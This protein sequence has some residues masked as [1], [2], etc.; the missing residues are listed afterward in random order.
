MDS[1]KLGKG[2]YKFTEEEIKKRQIS[3]I[4]SN[5]IKEIL[6][7]IAIVLSGITILYLY[8]DLFPPDFIP[9]F[10]YIYVAINLIILFLWTTALVQKRKLKEMNL[11]MPVMYEAT[12]YVITMFFLNIN[13][14][15]IV[16]KDL[17]SMDFTFADITIYIINFC[18]AIGLMG[19]NL[20][21]N[22]ASKVRRKETMGISKLTKIQF[23]SSVS[24]IVTLVCI[25]GLVINATMV[26]VSSG[27]IPSG[28]IDVGDIWDWGAFGVNI[29]IAVVFVA[30]VL[31][32]EWKWDIFHWNWI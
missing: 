7:I 10:S 31:L 17:N 24:L 32:I 14:I 20:I 12:F 13:Y 2:K 28:Q 11:K 27:V 3:A 21:R 5:F 26:Y 1:K 25:L 9:I 30:L 22:M 29:L 6:L 15:F 4:F 16:N 8:Y 19:F 23:I 18:V